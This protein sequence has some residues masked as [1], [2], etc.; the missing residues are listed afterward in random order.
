CRFHVGRTCV[1]R[2]PENAIEV[3]HFPASAIKPIAAAAATASQM[4][5]ELEAGE[6]VEVPAGFPDASL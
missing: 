5:V 2:Y 3:L 4:V 1:T 6:L